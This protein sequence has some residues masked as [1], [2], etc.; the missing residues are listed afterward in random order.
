MFPFSCTVIY[1]EIWRERERGGEVERKRKEDSI[2]TSKHSCHSCRHTSHWILFHP[3]YNTH[4]H[5]NTRAKHTL[6]RAQTD[7][8]THAELNTNST[9]SPSYS[10]HKSF[11]HKS[12]FL[13]QFIFR[14]HTTREPVSNRVTYF[15][16]RAYTGTGVSHSQ[17]REKKNREIFWKKMQV[18]GLEG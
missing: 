10:F 3:G 17:H 16:P 15:I 14:G 13:S 1:A 9:L 4:T 11:Y 5:T 8:H 7:T 6:T 18:N 2:N 12:C